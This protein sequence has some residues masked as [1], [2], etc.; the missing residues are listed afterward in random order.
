MKQSWNTFFFM[1]TSDATIGIF[2]IFFGLTVFLSTLGRFP[3]RELFYTD[4]GIVTFKT[5]NHFFPKPDWLFFRWMPQADPSL[6]I[7]FLVFMM[8]TLF[9]ILGWWTRV[10][11]IVV[12]L[13]LISL[14]NRNFFI[15]NA[16]D[17][18]MR[19]N[20]FFLMFSRAGGAY[21][22]DRWWQ[23]RRA[24]GPLP[25][26]IGAPWAQ[27]L[28]QL[29]VSYLYLNTVYL[30]LPG[31][32][33]LNGTALYYAFDYLELKRFDFKYLFYFLWQIKLA[34]Y[35]VMI[36]ETAMFTLVWFRKFRYWVLAFAF[37]LH[38]GINL[39]MQFPIFQY[40][41]M[42]GLIVFIYP[43]DLERWVARLKSASV[44]NEKS[45]DLIRRS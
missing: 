12:F 43:E 7:Y 15:D 42:T 21:S 29:Q 27:R 37:A 31:T 18:L 11:S 39:T 30:K 9:L 23:A 25:I 26:G 1:P 10:S 32:A 40:V 22:L 36:A 8:F 16:G 33:W 45:G 44:K 4:L 5:M 19:I 41:M 14:S 34:T 28:I 17:D 3:F 38:E 20:G 24:G 2:R 13:G 6:Q 35:S